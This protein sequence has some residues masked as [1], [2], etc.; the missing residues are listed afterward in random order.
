MCLGTLT[1]SLGRVHVPVLYHPLSEQLFP[2]ED[3][4]I[5]FSWASTGQAMVTRPD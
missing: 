3:E 1:T 4:E 5:L 2:K